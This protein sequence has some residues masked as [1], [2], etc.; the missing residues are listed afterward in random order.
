MDAPPPVAAPQPKLGCLP[1][2]MGGASF[3]PVL[4]VPL[5][6]V[7]IVYGLIKR[8]EGGLPLAFLGVGGIVL[9]VVL[10]GT[11]FYKG[12]VEKGGV[13]DV[14]KS[15]L[16]QTQV[17]GVVKELEFYRLQNGKYPAALKALEK[18]DAT[19]LVF[20]YEPFLSLGTKEVKPFAYELVDQGKHYY[21]FSRGPDGIEG[22]PDD[23]FPAISEQEAEKIGYRKKPR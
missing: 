22:T 11:L 5:G 14:L 23:I 17:T 1:Y 7:S 4:G 6:I 3:I 13:F 19:N 9:T 10:Y 16:V 21:L 15:Q 20:I 2:V 18:K 8:K 12:F